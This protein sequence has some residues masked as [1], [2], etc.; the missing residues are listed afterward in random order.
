MA[1]IAVDHA[2][3]MLAER[4]LVHAAHDPSAVDLVA[5]T[6]DWGLLVERCE[7]F[8]ALRAAVE[9]G[10][11]RFVLIDGISGLKELFDRLEGGPTPVDLPLAEVEKRHI[12][13]VLAS[14][15]GNKTRAAK[16]LGIDTKTLASRLKTYE[17]QRGA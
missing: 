13:R 14:Q 12:L 10:T 8:D 6:A 9:S 16:V 15:G 17:A 1:G 5:R 11:A 2:Q 3:W 7:T 4:L